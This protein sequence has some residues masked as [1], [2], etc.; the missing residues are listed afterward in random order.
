MMM[1][2]ELREFGQ[3]NRLIDV[4]YNTTILISYSNACLTSR[5]VAKTKIKLKYDNNPVKLNLT[6]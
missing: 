4:L 5:I 2:N 3:Q 6:S 1:A